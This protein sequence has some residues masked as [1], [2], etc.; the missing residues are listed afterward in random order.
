MSALTLPSFEVKG[1][2]AFKDLR[3]ERLGRVNLIVGKNNVGKTALLE[4]IELYAS[5]G[6][7]NV[8]WSLLTSRD[9]RTMSA[10]G[11][12]TSVDEQ[13]QAFRHLFYG[14]RRIGFELARIQIGPIGSRSKTLSI[15]LEWFVTEPNAEG[16][17]IARTLNPSEYESAD[18]ATPRLRSQVGNN[19]QFT[20]PLEIRRFRL[21]TRDVPP[22]IPCLYVTSNGLDLRQATALWDAITLTP[23]QDEV[24]NTLRL[25]AP[26]VRGLNFAGYRMDTQSAPIER[27]PIV[28][29]E[30]S[31]EPIPLRSLGDGMQRML[32]IALALVNAKDG[33]LLVDEVENGLHYTILPKLWRLIFETARRL[34]VQ[35]FAT[36][37]SWECLEAFQQVA[38][39]DTE[40][41]GLLIRLQLKGEQIVAVL[42]G[43]NDLG[44]A[45]RQEIEVR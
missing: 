37:H 42:I 11:R 36:S 17:S 24:T 31:E 26:G 18:D 6:A 40:S 44:I 4:A 1:F 33:I 38:E 29:I 45:T 39:E 25:L 27:I 34:N 9:E 15:A 5:S 28:S 2:R 16:V 41:E 13:I 7:P 35:V 10:P 3:I 8:I 22:L 21:R 30:G 19:V 32:G 20:D 23:L 12:S 14:R 43:E